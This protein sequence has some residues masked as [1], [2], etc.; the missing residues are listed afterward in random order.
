MTSSVNKKV[1]SA[2]DY[3][4]AEANCRYREGFISFV[5][6]KR[7]EVRIAHPE[8]KPKDITEKLVHIWTECMSE[9]DREKYTGLIKI[10][11]EAE[12][13]YEYEAEYDIFGDGE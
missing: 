4:E 9:E 2:N 13:E 5:Q 6:D 11:Y 3:A 8:L 1:Y 12:A 7:G 10:E